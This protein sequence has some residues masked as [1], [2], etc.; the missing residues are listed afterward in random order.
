MLS[1]QQLRNLTEVFNLTIQSDTRVS[2]A[3]LMNLGIEETFVKVLSKFICLRTT[4]S[5]SQAAQQLRRELRG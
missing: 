1:T 3:T 2:P 5:L 4:T